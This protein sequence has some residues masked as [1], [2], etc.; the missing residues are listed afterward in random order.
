LND[1]IAI[2][3]MH[4]FQHRGLAVPADLSISGFNNQDICE[5]TTPGLTSVDQQIDA[6]ILAATE[7]LLNQ[8]KFP[9]RTRAVVRLIPPALVVR[10]STGRLSA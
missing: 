1:E 5:I 4:E 3:A 10:E 6:T 7:V 2:G 8:I 9:T